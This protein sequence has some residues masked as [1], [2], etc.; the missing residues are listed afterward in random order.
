MLDHGDELGAADAREDAQQAAGGT[1]RDGFDQ[2][3]QEDVPAARADGHADADFARPLGDA[4][5]H[6]VHDADAADDAGR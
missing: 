2:E 3:L 6:D 4:D 5:E 1:E